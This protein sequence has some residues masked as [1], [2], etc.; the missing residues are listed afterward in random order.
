MAKRDNANYDI[1]WDRQ[2][3]KYG[4]TRYEK[5][6]IHEIIKRNPRRVFEV[7]IGN[8]LPIG[9]A[10]YRK[11]IDVHGCDISIKLVSSAKRNLGKQADDT[12]IFVGEVEE[13][14]GG[15]RY[16]V[17]Y[18]ARTSWYINNFEN[19]IRKMISMTENGYVIFDIMQKESLYYVKQA[20]LYRRSKILKFLGISSGEH[21]KLFFYSRYRI[22][23]LLKDNPLSFYS[24]SE[25]EITKIRDYWNTPKRFYVCKIKEELT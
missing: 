3:K 23:K 14:H 22:E 1:F 12:C 10:L 20:L 7:G 5:F 17:I 18:C 9:T 16:D 13:Y 2:T 15:G 8:G 24:H 6:I 11:G 19:T 25:I 4:V 21:M